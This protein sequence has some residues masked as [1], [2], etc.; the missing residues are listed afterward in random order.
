MLNAGLPRISEEILGMGG[1]LASHDW[2]T[3]PQLVGM[4][5]IRE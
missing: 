3:G 5:Y 4:A 1:K 2:L